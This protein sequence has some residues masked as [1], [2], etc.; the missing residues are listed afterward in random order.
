MAESHRS[1]CE[2]IVSLAPQSQADG[3]T[4]RTMID[5]ALFKTPNTTWDQYVKVLM[6]TFARSRRRL[7]R[8]ISR[9]NY[10]TG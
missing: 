5:G 7:L 3:P 6:H 8:G 9:R 2:P 4:A 1:V 10:E